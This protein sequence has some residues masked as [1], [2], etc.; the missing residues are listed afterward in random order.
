MKAPPLTVIDVDGD[1]RYVTA[2][3]WTAVEVAR[4]LR[5]PRALATLD[6]ALRSGKC[7]RADV[8][9]AALDQAGRRGIVAVR[10]LIALADRARSPRWRARPA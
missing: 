10:N 2:P 1:V 6:A 8:W 3:A 7:T 9:R 5:R 4:A